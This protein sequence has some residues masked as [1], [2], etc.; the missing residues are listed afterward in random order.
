[1]RSVLPDTPGAGLAAIDLASGSVGERLAGA[2]IWAQ[3]LLGDAFDE[4]VREFCAAD[5]AHPAPGGIAGPELTARFCDFIL[6]KTSGSVHDVVRYQR[7]RL[8][9]ML[10]DDGR[11]APAASNALSGQAPVPQAIR[12]LYPFRYVP[13]RIERF[14]HDVT[15][16]LCVSDQPE[17]T[18]PAAI[19]RQPVLMCFAQMPNMSPT[20]L[21]LNAASAQLL[22]NCAGGNR[23]DQLVA[24]LA[25]SL[26]QTAAADPATIE[27]QAL[28]MLARFYRAGVVA[29]ADRPAPAASLTCGS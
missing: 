7:A 12:E 1:M 14:D 8:W 15:P 9:A 26:A 18:D 3:P 20:E 5:G 10:G 2:L 27:A 22:E 19:A 13:V 11:T 25:A 28:T 6:A 23:A 24:E 17:V 16:V 4:F 29:F 21:R